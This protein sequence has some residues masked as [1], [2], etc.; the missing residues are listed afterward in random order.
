VPHGSPG[1]G[2][3]GRHP[4]IDL[5]HSRALALSV[6]L[7]NRRCNL[8]AADNSP[9]CSKAV[10]IAAASSSETMNMVGKMVTFTTAGKPGVPRRAGWNGSG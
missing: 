8:M 10:R 3:N 5:T 1:S 6:I 9:F 7:G 4:V 2:D